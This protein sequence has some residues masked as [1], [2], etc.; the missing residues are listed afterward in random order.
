ML[1]QDLSVRLVPIIRKKKIADN[2]GF[3][4]IKCPSCGKEIVLIPNVK[5]M[6][7]TI[8]DHAEIHKEQVKGRKAREEEAECIKNDLIRQVLEKAAK[9]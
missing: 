8:E 2:K 6:S 3:P 7:E 5:L 1:I 4:T 9:D